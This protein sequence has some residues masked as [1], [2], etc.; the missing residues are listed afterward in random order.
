[1]SG[2]KTISTASLSAAVKG[3][4]GTKGWSE[5]VLQYYV[6]D[7]SD[8]TLLDQARDAQWFLGPASNANYSTEI[9]ATLGR[10]AAISGLSFKNVNRANSDKADL[11]MFGISKLRDVFGP[12]EGQF[13]FPGTGGANNRL[14]PG[15]Y[16]SFGVLNSSDSHMS[17]TGELGGGQYAWWT[18]IHEVLHG[19]GLGHP[20]DRGNGSTRTSSNFKALDN[21]MYTVMSYEGA[22]GTSKTYGHAV[23]PMALDIAALQAIYGADSDKNDG[24]SSYR[25]TDPRTAAL[26]DND[27]MVVIGRAYY[28][29]WDADG[30]DTISY[31]G[32]QSALIN[33]NSATLG[34]ADPEGLGRVLSDVRG[35]AIWSKLGDLMR[36]PSSGGTK[37]LKQDFKADHYAGGFFS[38]VLH[39]NDGKYEGVDGGF[40][41]AS[42]AKIENA[43]GSGRQDLLIGNA[44]GNQLQGKGG[45][46][47]L[48][49]GDGGDRLYGNEGSDVLFGGAGNDLILGGLGRDFLRGGAGDDAIRGGNGRDHLT[50]G[51]GADDFIYSSLTQSGVG[52]TSRDRINEFNRG[53]DVIV[54]HDIDANSTRAGNQAFS[55]IGTD[56]FSGQAGELRYRIFPAITVI[57]ADTNG[58]GLADFQIELAGQKALS[59]QDFIL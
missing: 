26:K 8:S 25:L 13:D 12:F 34:G 47:F 50:G 11:V 30:R 21:E 4:T 3:V 48:F 35:S 5:K 10:I 16:R 44:L 58:D 18:V 42:G 56:E 33:L 38:R 29:I 22:T 55:F 1:M 17:A 39:L 57:S 49:G 59:A 41:I 36:G 46:D 52:A 31:S 51:Y 7:P 43:T 37:T 24:A 14:G 23:T 20:H 27:D 6:G 45:A 15:D 2:T 32:Q 54:V 28:A 40:S 53:K 19:L 9:D